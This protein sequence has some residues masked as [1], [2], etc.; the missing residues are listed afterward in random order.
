MPLTGPELDAP[1]PS[2]P[3]TTTPA[4]VRIER[5][6]SSGN[7]DRRGHS[8]GRRVRDP[9][10]IDAASP[11]GRHT[12][13]P[14]ASNAG[15]SALAGPSDPRQKLA[16]RRVP[17]LQHPVGPGRRQHRAVPTEGEAGDVA[18]VRRERPHARAGVRV[19]DLDDPV[20]LG[21]LGGEDVLFGLQATIP[22]TPGIVISIREAP[23]A[24]CSAS[25]ASGSTEPST[26]RVRSTASIA[27]RM[28][29]S[30]SIS[31]LATA[32]AASSLANATLASSSAR[33][34]SRSALL[35][36]ARRDERSGYRRRARRR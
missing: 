19:P 6:G 7:L 16:A 28:L 3:P 9:D 10:R 27:S 1:R 32:A 24:W 13:E 30:G 36:L 12:S 15:A 23:T 17:H 20:A 34:A 22:P 4:K 18:V 8:P 33:V 35:A 11:V 25:S 5:H 14:S 2:S 26:E 29:R 21:A 31:R